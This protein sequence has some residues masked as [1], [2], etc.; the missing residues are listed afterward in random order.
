M[1]TCRRFTWS[2]GR[3]HRPA[4]AALVESELLRHVIILVAWIAA[5]K[6]FSLLYQQ[7]IGVGNGT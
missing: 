3:I 1:S 2:E 6:A 4:A 7:Q 5:L